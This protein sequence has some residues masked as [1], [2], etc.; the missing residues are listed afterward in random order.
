MERQTKRAFEMAKQ[1]LVSSYVLAH[2]DPSLEIEIA[3][4]AFPYGIGA[5]LSQRWSNSTERP[6]TFASRSL[7][8]TERKYSQLDKEG[9]AFMF[10]ITKFHYYVFGR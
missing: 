1:A 7:N 2:F 6:V 9:F 8:E 10:G 3:C 5:V 4:D